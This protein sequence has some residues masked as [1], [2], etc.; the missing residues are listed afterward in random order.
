MGGV[1]VRDGVDG[2]GVLVIRVVL[3]VVMLVIKIVVGQW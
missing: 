2:G 3:M 1:D